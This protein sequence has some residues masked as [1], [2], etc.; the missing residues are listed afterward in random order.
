MKKL[1]LLTIIIMYR[2]FAFAQFT[3]STNHYISYAATGI[4]NKT[5]TSHSYVITNGIK[6][7]IRRKRERLN[8][9]GTWIY[10]RQQQL[11]TNNDLSSS[12][13]FNLY[14]LLPHFYYWGLTAFDKSYSLR[15]NYRLQAGF[16]AAYNLIDQENTS[17]NI[18]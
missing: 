17:L 2:Q 12:V 3:D 14:R 5:N 15:V 16:G 8:A 6:Y 7:S 13:D 11:L 9:G 4:L 18:S 10:G 1:L